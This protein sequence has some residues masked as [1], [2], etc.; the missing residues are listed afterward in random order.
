M[1]PRNLLFTG[2][3]GCGKTTL[4][5]KIVRQLTVPATG[6]FTQEIREGGKRVGFSIQTLDGQQ[7]V[8][9]HTRIASQYRVG[10]YRV[11]VETIDRIAVPA[12][13]PRTPEVLIIIDEIGRMECLSQRFKDGVIQALDSGNPVLGTIALKGNRFMETIKKRRDVR[14][15]HVSE[16][17][18]DRLALDFQSEGGMYG[19][20]C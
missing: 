19:T 6:F 17:N 8:M 3:P 10:R 16:E 2:L 18:R 14:I 12:L 11:S 9:A 20:G 1:N 15:V 5:R 13:K 7:G 4:I